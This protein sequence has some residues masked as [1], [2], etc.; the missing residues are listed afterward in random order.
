MLFWM[1]YCQKGKVNFTVKQGARMKVADS[2]NYSQKKKVLVVG[3]SVKF[4]AT[5]TFAVIKCI[6]KQKRIHT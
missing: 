2:T 5:N 4:E 3:G 6:A 1:L